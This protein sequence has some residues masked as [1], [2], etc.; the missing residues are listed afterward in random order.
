MTKSNIILFL[1]IFGL[2]TSC[3]AQ[4]IQIVI[5]D[6][7]FINK[8]K[9]LSLSKKDTLTLSESKPNFYSLKNSFS[10]SILIV[11]KEKMFKINDIDKETKSIFVDYEENTGD[12]CYVVNKI[13]GDAI[14]SS[15]M[16]N[17]K[18]CNSITNIYIYNQYNPERNSKPSVRLRRK[19]LDSPNR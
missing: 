6:N 3:K 16:N 13:Y 5:N 4:D 10:K 1:I 9:I 15:D 19:R 18:K 8:V 17:L 14:Q 12:G 7:N 11:Y 2:C